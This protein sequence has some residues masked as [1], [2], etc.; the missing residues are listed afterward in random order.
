MSHAADPMSG[1]L[2]FISP[3]VHPVGLAWVILV[4]LAVLSA[5]RRRW[6]AALLSG[7][8][9]LLLWSISQPFLAHPIFERLER[10]WIKASVADAPAADV[11]LIL[12]GGWRFSR[13]DYGGLDLTTGGDRW[14]AGLELCRRGRAPVLVVG[15]DS[16]GL[17]DQPP[18]SELLKGWLNDWGLGAVALHTLG[19]V[20]TT[21]DEA[22][23]MR[24]LARSHG[25]NR[26]LLVT[27]ALHMRRAIAVFHRAG[28]EVI[29]VACDFQV[30]RFSHPSRSWR[31]FPDEEAFFLFCQWWHEE[32]GW[33][34]YRL[35]GHA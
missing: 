35:L 28:L 19:P 31:P 11:V 5:R 25:W 1:F 34:A 12:G 21:R 32:L 10:P 14:I 24:D 3:L 13:A 30:A 33:L 22:E 16:V 6:P 2:K 8:G 4:V 20:R 27:S 9:A 23:R 15:G 17:D 29:P 18:E 7:L 26:I